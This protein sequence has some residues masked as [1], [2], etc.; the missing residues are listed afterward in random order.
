METFMPHC[1]IIANC[2]KLSKVIG[3]LKSRCLLIRI[4]APSD[5]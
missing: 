2:E 5:K 3:P 1:R 4:P